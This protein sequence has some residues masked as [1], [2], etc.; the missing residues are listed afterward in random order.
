MYERT[1]STVR[2]RRVAAEGGGRG[3]SSS[4]LHN[5][6][7]D[8]DHDQTPASARS[9]SV[10]HPNRSQCKRVASTMRVVGGW[11]RKG[12]GKCIHGVRCEI[13]Q[14]K[15]LRRDNQSQVETVR[16]YLQLC[17]LSLQPPIDP[18]P[19]SPPSGALRLGLCVC[20]CTCSAP[21]CGG[22]MYP[23]GGVR[24]HTRRI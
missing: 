6:R 7:L 24:L 8:V 23:G 10:S 22:G 15:R 17:Q 1:F 12:K 4:P 14:A 9:A 3:C 21:A 20:A 18:I 13:E 16:T 11:E 2:R 5:D 19:C